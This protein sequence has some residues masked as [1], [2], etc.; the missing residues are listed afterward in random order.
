[1]RLM[2]SSVDFND[3]HIVAVNRKHE[4]RVAGNGDKTEAISIVKPHVT[5]MLYEQ[6][7]RTYLLPLLTFTTARADVDPLYRPKPLM[8]VEF[9]ALYG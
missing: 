6:K 1:M 2:V 7:Y 3:S 4:V 9:G 8:S 5:Q